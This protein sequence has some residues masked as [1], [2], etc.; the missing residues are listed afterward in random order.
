M[1]TGKWVELP[2]FNNALYLSETPMS[3]FGYG[4]NDGSGGYAIRIKLKAG[5]H[6]LIVPAPPNCQ[7]V[8]DIG[9][10]TVFVRVFDNN[11]GGGKLSSGADFILCSSEPVHSWSYGTREFYDELS[12][13]VSRATNPPTP[14]SWLSYM[15]RPDATG[16]YQPS[17]WDLGSD[18]H[19]F[20][21]QQLTNT[22]KNQLVMSNDNEG[23]IFYNPDDPGTEAKKREEH[24]TTK[25][26]NW[27]N[28]NSN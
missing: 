6:F 26:P 13:D 4:S 14:N 28:E 19:P 5:V 25:I 17:I 20:T 10:N 27:F 23:K 22:L 1:G 2:Y 16:T 11:H 9:K 7:T 21:D 12:R 8:G 18:H 15:R 3:S 24:F